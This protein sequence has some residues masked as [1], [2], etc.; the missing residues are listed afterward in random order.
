MNDEKER[1]RLPGE[2]KEFLFVSFLLAGLS[3]AAFVLLFRDPAKGA[4]FLETQPFEEKEAE[5]EKT[6]L[7]LALKPGNEP[8]TILLPWSAAGKVSCDTAARR[9]VV[10]RQGAEEEEL[11]RITAD[12]ELF[13]SASLYRSPEESLYVFE[14]RDMCVASSETV[15]EGLKIRLVPVTELDPHCFVLILECGSDAVAGE[16]ARRADEKLAETGENIVLL[17]LGAENAARTAEERKALIQSCGADAFIRLEMAEKSVRGSVTQVFCNTQ[18]YI[19]GLDSVVL[20]DLCESGVL[21]EIGGP[22]G[23]IA[24]LA[25][26][27]P[28]RELKLPV[29]VLRIG[30][31]AADAENDV[32]KQNDYL[33]RA[34]AG[35]AD[36]I[37]RAA[38]Y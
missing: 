9:L 28:L 21:A 25:E 14:L 1:K 37:R 11:P 13:V 24:E 22:A 33:E 12:P 3:V 27:D 18:Y 38:R 35:L 16:L 15:A 36:A 30:R 7:K 2:V 6:E 34:A 31:S 10:G 32:K 26:D 19:P 8:L 29:C 17:R 4:A 23:N 20:A 5:A